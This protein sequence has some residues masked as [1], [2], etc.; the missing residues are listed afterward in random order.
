MKNMRVIFIYAALLIVWGCKKDTYPGGTISPYIALYDIRGLYKGNDVVLTTDNMDGSNSIAVMVV[1]DHSGNNLPPS[2]LVVQDSRRLSLLRGISIPLGAEAADYVPGDSLIIHVE[3]KVLKKVDGILELTGIKKEDITKVSSGNTIPIKQVS[4]NLF[5]ANPDAYESTLA[6]IVKGTFDP[7]PAAK[8]VLSGDKVLNDGFGDITLHTEATAL[9][10]ED[11]MPVNANFYGIF[12]NINES[13]QFR[14]RK[15]AD[16]EVLSTTIE[17]APVLITGFISDVK[18]G[19][20]NYEYIQL[21]ATKDIDFAAT[22]YAVVVTNNANASTPT[23]YPAKG[24]ATGGMRTFKFNLFSGNAAKGTF[25]YVGGDGKM[26]NGAASTSMNTSNWI[27]AFNYVTNDGD[28]FGTKTSG[29][30]ANS[31][32]A[33][34]MAVFKDTVVTV[35]SRPVDVMFISAGGS[36]YTE[37]PPAKGYRIANTDFYDVIN[38]ITKKEQPFYRAGSN[39]LNLTYNTADLGYFIMLGGTYNATLGKWTRVRTQTNVL[40]SKTSAITEIEGSGS[41]TLK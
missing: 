19:D 40:L 15:A 31:G 17:I 41:T 4:T 28:G 6:I 18:G 14:V 9:F 29:L 8:D 5:L 11:L 2:L 1:S 36:L 34:G 16:V 30:L 32:N 20:G 25:F 10:A 13:P 35:N 33:F 7:L 27:R 37:G 22:P 26:I 38:P 39:T 21:M 23:G 12:F 3:G 24:W